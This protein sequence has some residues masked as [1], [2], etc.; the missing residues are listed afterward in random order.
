[1][2]RRCAHFAQNGGGSLDDYIALL[3]DPPLA[4]VADLGGCEKIAAELADLLVARKQRNPLWRSTAESIEPETLFG[5]GE[6]QTR[7]SVLNLFGLGSES[8]KHEF[9]NQIVMRLYTWIKKHPA[10]AGSLRGLLVIDEARDFVPSRGSTACKET[11]CRMTA[12]ARKFGLGIV[13]AT[14]APKDVD[15]RIVNNCFTQF[16]GQFNS[17]AAIAAVRDLLTQKRVAN[18]DDI[19]RLRPRPVLFLQLQRHRPGLQNSDA[20]VPVASRAAG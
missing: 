7:V 2:R 15:H 14:Q 5:L 18:P 1:M 6:E 9:L 16:Y 10:P 17:P 4:A 13:F 8:S 3:R 12:Q 20:H 19:T 11:L